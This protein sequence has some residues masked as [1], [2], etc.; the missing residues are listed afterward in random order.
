M[1]ENETGKDE[2]AKSPS[3]DLHER[4]TCTYSLPVS[5]GTA[6]FWPAPRIACNRG[7]G[8]AIEVTLRAAR[9]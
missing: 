9:T 7:L 1:S 8:T 5:N 6:F 3:L 4:R 2:C